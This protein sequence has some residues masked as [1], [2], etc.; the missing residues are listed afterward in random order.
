MARHAHITQNNKFTISLQYFKKWVIQ[1]IFCMQISIKT[2]FKLI[3]S[4]WSS[5]CFW[6]SRCSSI[7]KIPKIASLQFFTISQ[8]EARDKVDLLHADNNQSFLQVDLS[9]K[10]YYHYSWAFIL[11]VLKV[12]SRKYLYSIW[13]KK[14]R[15]EF[16]FCMQINIKTAA[17]RY[18]C[19]WWKQPDMS[20]VPKIRSL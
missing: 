17:S 11:K 7:P 20:K 9:T 18:Y 1:L 15:M 8:K 5:S 4:F 12:T 19:F 2:W 10:W 13:K 16:I 6:W 3:P 14:L